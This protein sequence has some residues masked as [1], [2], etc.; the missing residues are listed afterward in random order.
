[1][2]PP[3]RPEFGEDRLYHVRRFHRERLQALAARPLTPSP[4]TFSYMGTTHAHSA[5]CAA[6]L[7]DATSYLKRVHETFAKDGSVPLDKVRSG[8]LFGNPFTE[9][10]SGT[11]GFP[12]PQ[13]PTRGVDSRK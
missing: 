4:K 5:P 9:E 1:M 11:A 8:Y 12:R 13:S 3:G 6:S 2:V 7:A 10:P